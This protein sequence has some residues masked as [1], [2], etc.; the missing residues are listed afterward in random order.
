MHFNNASLTSSP[1]LPDLMTDIV[2]K[3]KCTAPCIRTDS[4]IAVTGTVGGIFSLVPRH[5]WG[6]K[7]GVFTWLQLATSPLGG[8]K[9]YTLLH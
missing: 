7:G 3:D 8:T 9:T 1:L 5:P 6:E 2:T 4:F